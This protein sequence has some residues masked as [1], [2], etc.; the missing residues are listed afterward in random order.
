MPTAFRYE[1]DPIITI[2]PIIEPEP[3]VEN[4]YSYENAAILY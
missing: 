3:I 1:Y 4:L 2:D